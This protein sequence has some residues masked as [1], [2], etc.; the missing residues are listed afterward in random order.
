M[1]LL[2]DLRGTQTETHCS[3]T[4]SLGACEKLNRDSERCLL[5]KVKLDYDWEAHAYKRC[6][7]CTECKAE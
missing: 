7:G 2:I 1:K 5:F 6:E 3:M 4:S